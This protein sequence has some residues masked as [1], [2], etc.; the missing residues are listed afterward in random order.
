MYF[1]FLIEDQSGEV[2]IRHIMEKYK[3]EFPE[4]IYETKSFRGIGGIPKNVMANKVKTNKLLTD[5]PQYLRGFD[6]SLQLVPDA[7][8]FIVLDNDAN[9]TTQFRT[10]LEEIACESLLTLDYVFCIAVEEIEAW[11]LGDKTA[12]DAAYPDR[13][14]RIISVLSQYRQDSICGTWEK[15]ADIVIKG[16]YDKYRKTNPSFVQ[17]GKHKK[18]WAEQIGAQMDIRRNASPSFNNMISALDMRV[19]RAR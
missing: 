17:T 18:E 9:D 3:R 16:G 7:C 12:L 10:A 15:L 2:L 4:L 1:Y 11:L 5:L 14:G 8:L 19:M 13:H 6:K